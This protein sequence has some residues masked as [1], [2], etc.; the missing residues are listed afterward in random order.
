MPGQ[1]LKR[2]D[3][4]VGEQARNINCCLWTRI[5]T[6]R[7]YDVGKKMDELENVRALTLF[8]LIASN[9]ARLTRKRMG[10][11]VFSLS[12]NFLFESFLSNVCSVMF[13]MSTA[14]L[15]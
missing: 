5:E 10:I 11:N 6:R 7:A 12:L 14:V 4:L 3:G 8:F 1:S 13:K 15:L 2:R 9:A